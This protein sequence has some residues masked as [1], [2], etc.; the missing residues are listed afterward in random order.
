M[1]DPVSRRLVLPLTPLEQVAHYGYRSGATHAV[2]P[3]QGP[4]ETE[5]LMATGHEDLDQLYADESGGS[6]DK[7]G[8]P[9]ISCHVASVER[10]RDG[11]HRQHPHRTRTTPV[12]AQQ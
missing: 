9:R 8:R 11:D 10:E 1:E 12:Q 7:R 3:L 6:R 2:R 4:R 5:H